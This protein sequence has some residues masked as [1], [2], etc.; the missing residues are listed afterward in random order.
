MLMIILAGIGLWFLIEGA[1]YALAPDA[2]KRF[3]DWLSNLPETSIRQAGI[4][5]MLFGAILLYVIVRF[6]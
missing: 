2:M 4:F 3:G 6:G 5:S 1:M